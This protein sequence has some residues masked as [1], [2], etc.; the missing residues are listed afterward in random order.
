MIGTVG[1]PLVY[2]LRSIPNVVK[3]D[4]ID[5]LIVV[6]LG[7][8]KMVRLQAVVVDCVVVTDA[9]ADADETSS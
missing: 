9:D 2:R 3:S 6:T 8:E 7:K 1:S 4:R 5:D